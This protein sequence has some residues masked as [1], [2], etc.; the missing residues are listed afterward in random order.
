MP[1]R[2]DPLFSC[3]SVL[4]TTCIFLLARISRFRSWLLARSTARRVCG[5]RCLATTPRRRATAGRARRRR[6]GRRSRPGPRRARGRQTGRRGKR[7]VRENELLKLVYKTSYILFIVSFFP[8]GIPRTRRTHWIKRA[9]LVDS[10]T[11]V[12][13]VQFA[14]KH[15]GM[16]LATCST[17]G[18]VSLELLIVQGDAQTSIGYLQTLNSQQPRM[19]GLSN[20]D[21]S[22]STLL[23]T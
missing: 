19:P 4:Y 2:L 7:T 8:P 5:R 20:F 1:S 17:D 16:M 14:P 6:G 18:M 3:C 12:T 9:Q 10:R 13:D 15:L 23:S 22:C 11:S 21:K